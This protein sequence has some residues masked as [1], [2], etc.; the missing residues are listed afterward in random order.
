MLTMEMLAFDFW[1][2]PELAYEASKAAVETLLLYQLCQIDL[3]VAD[4]T[5]VAKAVEDAGAALVF[6]MII[7]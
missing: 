1:A 7:P 2:V 5:Q 6:T 3:S 4:I